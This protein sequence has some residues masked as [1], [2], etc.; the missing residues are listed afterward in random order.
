MNS[1]RYYKCSN[2]ETE[3]RYN[4]F[5]K[6]KDTNNT[7]FSRPNIPLSQFLEEND[8]K[9]NYIE[10]ANAD[11]KKLSPENFDKFIENIISSL[12]KKEPGE[13]EENKN[14]I[15]REALFNLMKHGL[16]Y[17]KSAPIMNLL[18]SLNSSAENQNQRKYKDFDYDDY[19]IFYLK[20]MCKNFT[21]FDDFLD[22]MVLLSEYLAKNFLKSNSLE[23]D[24]NK[25]TEKQKN[26]KSE[27]EKENEKE[28]E[29]DNEKK[30]FTSYY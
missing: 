19:I 2:I 12:C 8:K 18:I 29:K 4:S 26:E 14:S 27:S 28:K 13:A 15:T 21:K 23:S 25:K 17:H 22:S 20:Q 3:R 30:K 11:L 24:Q 9:S 16:I 6:K 10:F 7:H 5:W 1:S